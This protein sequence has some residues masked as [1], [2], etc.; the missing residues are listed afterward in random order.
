MLNMITTATTSLIALELHE[1]MIPNHLQCYQRPFGFWKC[2]A[3][4]TK[5]DFLESSC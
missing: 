5:I 1:S 4:K 3:R 2:S